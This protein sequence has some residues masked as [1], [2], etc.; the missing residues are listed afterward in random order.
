VPKTVRID[1]LSSTFRALRG[2]TVPRPVRH[3]IRIVLVALLVEYLL[4]PQLAGTRHSWHLLVAASASWLAVAVLLEVASLAVYAAL[5]HQLIP[6]AVRPSYWRVVRIDLSTL[7]VSHLV[8]AGSAVGAGLGYRLLTDAGVPGVEA[9][10]VKGTQA[11]G[12]A[13]VLNVLLWCSLVASILLDGFS[14]VYGPV[15]AVGLVLLTAAAA[16]LLTLRTRETQV[17]RFLGRWLGRLPLL[18]PS[19]VSAGVVSAAAYLREFTGDRRRLVTTSA[20]AAANWLLDAGALWACVRAFGHTLLPAALFVPY[21][22]ANVLAVLP[23]TPAG[24]GVVEA[25]LIPAL[26]GFTVPRGI[27]ILGVLAWR[28]LSFLLP[29]PVGLVAYLNLPTAGARHPAPGPVVAGGRRRT[30]TTLVDSSDA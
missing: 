11:V 15:A 24:L 30:G 29:I 3:V 12:S 28:G 9:V 18:T 27:A 13:L 22:I 10:S 5:T 20:L 2:L 14:P 25:F 8:P 1:A 4:V 6:Q 21:G 7:A 26:V 19:G 23:F 16:V 17:A